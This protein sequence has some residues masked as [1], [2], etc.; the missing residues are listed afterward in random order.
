MLFIFSVG[1]PF[2]RMQ[3][4]IFQDARLIFFD[5]PPSPILTEY[6]VNV[7][8]WKQSENTGLLKTNKTPQ[9][10]SFFHKK[11]K[12]KNIFKCRKYLGEKKY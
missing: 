6:I 9:N 11:L 8:K 2:K 3:F 4:K 10:N 5:V 12:I 1:G 7:L